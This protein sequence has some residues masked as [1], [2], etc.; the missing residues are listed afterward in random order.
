MQKLVHLED[1]LHERVV[2]QV[3]A[4]EAVANAIRRSRAGLSDPN[5]PDRL[6][7][8]PRAD[9]RRQDRARASARRLPVRRRARDR[10]RRHERVPGAA[11]GLAAGRRA[12]R[13]RRLRGGRAAHGGGPPP[14]VQR[15]AAR[16][17]GEGA[18]RRVQHPAAAAR[19]RPAHR[20]SGPHG[21][22]PEH[23][24]DHDV[25]PRVQR[26]SPTR[27]SIARSRKAAVLD[28]VRA[29]VPAGVR[30]PDRRDRRVRSA[31]PRRDPARSW[32]SSSSAC[33]T[34]ARGARAHPRRS[35]TR[36]ASTSRTRATTRRSA[37]GR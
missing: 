9:R 21:R 18:H 30:E 33:A 29:Y 25:E 26:C 2:D 34:T 37:P 17:D 28:E 31:R 12:A 22:L 24:R 6:V 1:A 5:R 36:R 7:P 14:P 13:L 15:R 16:R 8:V 3:E 19:R 32:T 35:P 20:R 27:R 23:D 11:H 4:V 10:A